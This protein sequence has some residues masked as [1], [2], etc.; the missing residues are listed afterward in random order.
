MANTYHDQLT[1]SD[2]HDNKVYPA[3]GTPLPSWTQTDARYTAT[4]SFTSH[5]TNTSNPH[6]VT[7][8]Q[9]GRTTAQWNANQLQGRTIST[10]APADGQ[11][12][13]WNAAVGQWIPAGQPVVFVGPA[14][15]I[16]N[17]YTCDGTADQVEIMAAGNALPVTGGVIY[18]RGGDYVT[19]AAISFT[20]ENLTILGDGPDVTKIKGTS[21]FTLLHVGGGIGPTVYKNYRVE[22]IT[23]DMNSVASGFSYGVVF[24]LCQNVRFRDCKVINAGTNAKNQFFFG[25]T[26]GSANEYARNLT[27]ENCVF[28]TN[29]SNYESVLFAQAHNIKFLN[30]KVSNSTAPFGLLQYGSTQLLIQGS[31]FENGAHVRLDG[32]PVEVIGN[33]FYAANLRLTG[34]YGSQILGNTFDG[35]PSYATCGIKLEAYIPESAPELAWFEPA[36]PFTRSCSDILISNNRFYRTSAVAISANATTAIQSGSSVTVLDADSLTIENNVFKQTNWQGIDVKAN[37]LKVLNNRFYNSGQAGTS[38]VRYNMALAAKYGLI[39][40]N[41]S[42]D[43]QGTPTTVRDFFIDNQYLTTL[44]PTMDLTFR[45]NHFLVGGVPYFYTGSGFT[46]TKPSNITIKGANNLGINPEVTYNQ[47]SVTGATTF[48]RKNGRTIVAMLAG[49]LTPTLA[50]GIFDGEELSLDL[51]Q[52]ATGGRTCAKP[53]NSK[54]PGGTLPISTTANARDCYRFRWDGSAWLL[55]GYQLNLS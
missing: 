45:D 11:F 54:V 36:F 51:T 24:E 12:L 9:V 8:T 3:T 25:T 6:N 7:A 49:N 47:G 4:S 44:I 40:G 41:T 16:G 38:T 29:N 22:G 34:S 30:S 18:V 37:H 55:V 10:T 20:R 28:D 15:T 32:D 35:G 39:H 43:D 13:V 17:A 33:R 46:S 5:T 42:Y 48:D 26:S 2:L 50:A 19:S 1:G 21:G 14:G 27:V 23:F 52:D 53:V 31:N